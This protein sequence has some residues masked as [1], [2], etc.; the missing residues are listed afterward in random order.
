MPSPYPSLWIPLIREVS[1]AEMCVAN[2]LYHLGK[3]DHM[4]TGKYSLAFFDTSIGLERLMKVLFLLDYALKN[5]GE[6]PSREVL[7]N[8][9]G[10]DLKGLWDSSK[11]IRQRLEAGGSEFR[12]EMPDPTLADLIIEV[13]GEFAKRTRYYNLDYLTGSSNAEKDPLKMWWDTVGTYLLKDYPESR[14]RQDQHAAAFYEATLGEHTAIHQTQLDGEHVSDIRQAT[15]VG[16][17]GEWVQEQ[18]RFHAATLVRYLVEVLWELHRESMRDPGLELPHFSELF[19]G[20]Y[21]DDTFLKRRK[22]FV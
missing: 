20:F 3:A 1:L 18:A 7:K 8:Q 12:F 15:F 19:V 21:N 17:Q 5:G 9:I 13:L 16:S 10:H 4:S 11:S 6:F 2:G 14:R 22:T